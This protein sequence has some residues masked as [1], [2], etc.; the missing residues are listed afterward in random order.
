MLNITLAV[1]LFIF[2]IPSYT[3]VLLKIVTNIISL[4]HFFLIIAKS[5]KY[6]LPD[7][8][9]RLHFLHVQITFCY[10]EYKK[11]IITKLVA[12]KLFVGHWLY[13]RITLQLILLSLFVSF[14]ILLLKTFSI[15][16]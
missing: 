11:N 13:L 1:P 4:F 5:L 15:I 10:P 14:A 2:P 6:I 8:L 7:K 3:T 16:F 9:R 12:Y